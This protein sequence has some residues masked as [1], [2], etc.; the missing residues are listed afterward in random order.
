MKVLKWFGIAIAAIIVVSI[1]ASALG[2]NDTSTDKPAT[3]SPSTASDSTPKAPEAI[4][5]SAPDLC[6][7]YIEN[8]VAAD[9]KYK[10]KYLEIT[11][12]ID[13]IKKDITDTPYVALTTD[14]VIRRVQC[15]FSKNE[16]SVLAELKK[17]QQITII[18]KCDGLMMNVIIRESKIQ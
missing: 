17:G 16:S 6:A 10:G 18:G 7:A 1:L 9:E 3:G 11:G 5:I 14:D 12:A 15:M 4:K 2:G 13:D 8:E